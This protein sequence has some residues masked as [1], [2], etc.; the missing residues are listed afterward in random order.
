VRR[1]LCIALAS[2]TFGAC[3]K[4][5]EATPAAGSATAPTK[6][7]PTKGGTPAGAAGA[8]PGVS[9]TSTA[10]PEVAGTYDKAFAKLANAD[11]QT[12]IVFVRGCPALACTDNV[13]ELESIA[14]KC[15]T[16]FLATA[17]LESK[18]P[19]PGDHMAT[20]VVAGP[21]NRSSTI[22]LEQVDLGLTVISADRVAGSAAQKTTESAVSGSFDAEICDRM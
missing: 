17:T 8:S 20:M 12:T 5:Q 14:Q 7:A 1:A 19:K 10:N 3:G 18:E 4:K 2:L 15:P 13:F 9:I 16:A 21:A 22:T 6:G 11:E